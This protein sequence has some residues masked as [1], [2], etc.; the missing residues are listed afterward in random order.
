MSRQ[1]QLYIEQLITQNIFAHVDVRN[2]RA[3]LNLVAEKFYCV[4]CNAIIARSNIRRHTKT[5]THLTNVTLPSVSVPSAPA[6]SAPAP[7]AA[8][9]V[10]E[11]ECGICYDPKRSFSG[12][13]TCRN[14]ICSDCRT[15]ITKC[16][17]CR[18]PY[19]APTP[20]ITYAT[21]RRRVSLYN[22]LL[23]SASGDERAA[24]VR[25]LDAT[26]RVLAPHMTE[27]DR[28]RLFF[29]VLGHTDEEFTWILD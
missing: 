4:A 8:L 2:L 28:Y 13:Q 6:P 20:T 15:C 27:P 10:V 12:C 16:P 25:A 17:F 19:A 3:E 7:S 11:R 14:E 5:R 24:L 18:Q 29:Y 23:A 9:S 26:L 1:L 21:A 22:R